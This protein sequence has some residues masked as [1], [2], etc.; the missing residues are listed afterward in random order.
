MAL[1]E[2]GQKDWCL[3]LVVSASQKKRQSDPC[4][5][6]Q[7]V[8]GKTHGR[9]PPAA[10]EARIAVLPP[11]MGAGAGTGAVSVEEAGVRFEDLEDLRRELA[12]TDQE[13]AR[14]DTGQADA[15]MTLTTPPARSPFELPQSL[16]P[17]KGRPRAHRRLGFP[18]HLSTPTKGP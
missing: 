10:G 13:L 1:Q 16:P 6:G 11:R 15:P 3:V 18:Q 17:E 12:R 2:P 7:L 8:E 9:E 14:A 5:P 4:L